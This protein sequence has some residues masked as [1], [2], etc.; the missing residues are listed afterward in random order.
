MQRVFT[1]SLTL[2]FLFFSFAS[3]T[4]GQNCN[5]TSFT[6]TSCW[7]W[8]DQTDLRL[9]N[10]E[11][12]DT[13]RLNRAIAATLGK[14]IFDE[15]NYYLGKPIIPVGQQPTQE[16]LTSTLTL[17]SFRIIEGTGRSPATAHQSSK[18]IQTQENSAIFSIG[19]N[20][21]DVSIRDL[22]LIGQASGTIGIL[23]ESTCLVNCSSIGFQFSNLSFYNFDKG[24]W[25]N[26]KDP[27][28]GPSSPPA[29]SSAHQ[30]Q[31]DSVRLDHSSF[32]NCK[33]GVHINSY[34]SGWYM[35]D[36]NF[37]VRE[38]LAQ[39]E[40]VPRDYSNPDHDN[41][42]NSNI[43]NKTYGVFLERST[44]TSLNH[45][46]GNGGWTDTSASG[47]STA[48]VY[49][50]EHANL[51]I[52]NSVAERFHDDVVIHGDS[53]NF[54]INL[55]NNTFMNGV[56]IKRATVYSTSN[57]FYTNG[58][59]LQSVA[60]ATDYAQVYSFGDKFCFEGDSS[61]S[62]GR[63]YA[64]ST[65]AMI[66]NSSTQAK[67]LTEVPSFMENSL[68]VARTNEDV[69]D[70]IPV[71]SVRS[72]FTFSP[73]MRFNV[74]GFTYDFSRSETDGKLVVRGS[75]PYYA[76]YRFEMCQSC[77]AGNPS[78]SDVV[79]AVKIN[80]NGSLTLGQVDY[81]SLGASEDGTLVYCTTCQQTTTCTP[82]GSGA[83]AKRISGVW[84]CN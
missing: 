83:F 46:V 62:Q 45:L 49:V 64:T 1:Q 70:L 38:G 27:R 43:G 18:I 82:G 68:D 47:N 40:F 76:G 28:S 13:P 17:Y 29:P 26:A 37:K 66:A 19:P 77:G 41:D 20:V 12:N 22:A 59:Q 9:P 74:R 61:C 72:Y 51:T 36:L 2:F 50:Q 7:P 11:P 31:F 33:I 53:L 16:Q 69:N 15:D 24:I 79:T 10:G 5:S 65:G 84:Q 63:G 39:G 14:V 80:N 78:P 21:T 42:A 71:V 67:N 58:S 35:S 52:Q 3:L 57:Q 48:L 25:V 54:P 30:W 60:E 75:Q 55:L 6:Y 81:Y 34:N 4:T 32:D 44:Y 73:L 56:R 23:A 8:N